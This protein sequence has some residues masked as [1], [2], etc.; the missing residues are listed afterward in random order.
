MC[1]IVD[2]L[3]EKIYFNGLSFKFQII[4]SKSVKD[5]LQLVEM[6]FCHLQE[7]AYLI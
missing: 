6:F 7:Y 4:F 5:H 3:F 2:L 1:Q